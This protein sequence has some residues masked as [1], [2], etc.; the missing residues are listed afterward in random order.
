MNTTLK[1]NASRTM[2]ASLLAMLACLSRLLGAESVNIWISSQQDKIYY[3][4][5]V[6]L[7]QKEVDP[8]FAAN[9]Q[10]F[11]FREMPDK[12]AIALK[13]QTNT[14]DI[15]QLDEVFFGMY[16]QG[17][18]TP[19]VD[20]TDR[21]K[22]A[23]LDVD[24]LPQR[25]E[26][27]SHRGKVLGLPQSLSAV[28]LY[29]RRDLFEQF[30]LS[31]SQ[32]QTW[33]DVM[34]IGADLVAE[35]QS[36][37]A[38]DPSYFGIFLRQR[39]GHL[40]DEDGGVLPDFD[41][42]VDTL[43]FLG[44]LAQSQVGLM[45]DRS[46]IFDPVFF[47][48]DVANNEIMAIVGADWYGLDM[49]QQFSPELEGEWGIMPL[50]A[51]RDEE[52]KTDSVR[53]STFAGQGL[54]IYKGSEVIDESWEFVEFVMTNREANAQRFLQGNSFPAFK[55]AFE[56]LRLLQPQPFFG[57]DSM[58][59]IFVELAP[60]IPRVAMNPKR[61]MAV[62]MIREGLLSGIMYGEGDARSSLTR[63]KE[64]LESGGGPPDEN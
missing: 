33:D 58:G 52:T 17:A 24:I 62:F 10:A 44:E 39:G 48:G 43:E 5:M 49:I 41:L 20:L 64:Q 7:Y 60:D 59:Q 29:Y 63:F 26:L 16:L 4:N 3:D 11:G 54:V 28:V 55:P 14:P 51:W 13:T 6:R 47:G 30:S 31:P 50:P 12:L 53:T 25:L 61:P 21:V 56:D 57:Y 45:P 42:A 1:R 38:L 34:R 27:F 46:T 2:A 35:N 40:F 32:F 22:K 8:N 15:V 18:D 37:L 23:K 19:F 36:F 9:V